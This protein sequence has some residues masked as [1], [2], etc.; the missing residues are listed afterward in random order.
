MSKIKYILETTRYFNS[1]EE[2]NEYVEQFKSNMFNA[3]YW[4][5]LNKLG[6]ASFVTYE[7]ANKTKIITTGRIETTAEPRQ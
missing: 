1:K 6:H 7:T 4:N 5:R 3:E 2:L